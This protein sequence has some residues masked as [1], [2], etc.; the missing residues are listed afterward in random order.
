MPP[1]EPFLSRA[2]RWLTFG[3]AVSILLSIAISQIL[4]ALAPA[5]RPARASITARGLR[6]ITVR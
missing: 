4:L 6:S 1:P 3:A 2:A 5:Y